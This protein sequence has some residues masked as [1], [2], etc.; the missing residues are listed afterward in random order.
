MRMKMR[1]YA[2]DAGNGETTPGNICVWVPEDEGLGVGLN[3]TRILNRIQNIIT[4]PH[5]IR[6]SPIILKYHNQNITS[7]IE[8]E[9]T[10]SL[11]KKYL[12]ISHENKIE[13]IGLILFV[14]IVTRITKNILNSKISNPPDI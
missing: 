14:K 1:A 2:S 4:H 6:I 10:I 8:I 5:I 3:N 9:Y 13:I 11:K 7:Y 12:L